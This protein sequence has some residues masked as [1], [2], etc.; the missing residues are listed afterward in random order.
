MKVSLGGV[1]SSPA[2]AELML[3]AINRGHEIKIGATGPGVVV[4]FMDYEEN[5]AAVKLVADSGAIVI[6]L[7]PGCVY[8][9]KALPFF[10][11]GA[12]D[13]IVIPFAIG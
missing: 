12:H 10:R 2:I 4:F 13:V 3:V 7:H 8:E 11:A 1:F 6:V 9:E 5:L